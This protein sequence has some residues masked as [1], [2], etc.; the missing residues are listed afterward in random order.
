MSWEYTELF[1]VCGLLEAVRTGEK[2]AF[3]ITIEMVADAHKQLKEWGM[4]FD[5]AMEKVLEYEK[6]L[7]DKARREPDTMLLMFKYGS[8]NIPIEIRKIE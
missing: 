2:L 5:E 8:L 6:N 7:L 3:E 4:T 1:T